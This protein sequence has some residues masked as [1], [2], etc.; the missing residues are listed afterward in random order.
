ME[1]IVQ[2]DYWFYKR[3]WRSFWGDSDFGEWINVSD[4]FKM[5]AKKDVGDMSIGHQHYY[6]LNNDVGDRFVML[7]A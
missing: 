6:M 5:D 4:N 2:N 1:K 7:E 3:N